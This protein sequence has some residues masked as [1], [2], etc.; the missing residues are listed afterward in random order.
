SVRS[1]SVEAQDGAPLLDFADVRRCPNFRPRDRRHQIIS[2][3][4]DFGLDKRKNER[5]LG[6]MRLCSGAMTAHTENPC[7][8]RPPKGR[9]AR[10]R[11]SR[12]VAVLSVM[13][14]LGA[15][16]TVAT[17]QSPEAH[18]IICV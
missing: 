14:A 18:A 7:G 1:N 13:V 17:V 11:R 6:V 3:T 15:A 4:T 2:V 8:P 12:S 9:R 5:N 10:N 16:G